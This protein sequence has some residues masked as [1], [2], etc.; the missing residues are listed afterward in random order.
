M[1]YIDNKHVL[2]QRKTSVTKADNIREV[3]HAYFEMPHIY[4]NKTICVAFVMNRENKN[5][6]DSRESIRNRVAEAAN[7]PKDV[8]LGVPIITMTGRLELSI[9]NYHGII[10]YTEFLVR[11]GTRAGQIKVTGQH[12]QIEYYT[13]DEM[14][15]SGQ[16]KKVEYC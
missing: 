1:V 6:N 5:R 13:N 8:V 16:I 10:E 3:V 2:K 4:Y 15:I 11:I 14:K 9:E 12:L 7:M